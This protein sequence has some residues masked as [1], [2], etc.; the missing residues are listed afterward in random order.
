MKI[1]DLTL[2][3]SSKD[4][5]WEPIK[6]HWIPFFK[7][8]TTSQPRAAVPHKIKMSDTW[9]CPTFEITSG[10]ACATLSGEVL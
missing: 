6:K 5:V 3:P 9:V 10:D 4:R 8:M 1:N 7:G 2:S